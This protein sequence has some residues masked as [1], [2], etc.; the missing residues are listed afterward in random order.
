[1]LLCSSSRSSS[2]GPREGSPAVS[3]LPSRGPE[4]RE[5]SHSAM[6]LPP[7]SDSR[8]LREAHMGAPLEGISL[9]ALGRSERVARAEESAEDATSQM[10]R[11]GLE[12]G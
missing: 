4:Q 5:G 12:L 3:L 7:K 8:D 10:G 2:G 6:E 1:M 11:G 9:R